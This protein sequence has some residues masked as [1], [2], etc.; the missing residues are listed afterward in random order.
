M[1][2]TVN[3]TARQLAPGST[4]ADLVRQLDLG[5]RRIAIERNGHIVP[6]GE[7]ASTLVGQGDQIEIVVAVGGG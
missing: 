7:H 3:G 5:E 4:L 6:R 2:L 1:N